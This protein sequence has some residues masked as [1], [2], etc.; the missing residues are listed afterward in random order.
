MGRVDMNEVSY[1]LTDIVRQSSDP[2]FAD[3]LSR[4]C[5]G[6]HTPKDIEKIKALEDTDTSNWQEKAVSLYLTN[7]L[8]GKENE[9]ALKQINNEKFMKFLI[10]DN[11]SVR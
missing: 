7:Y 5:E 11:V 1:E 4:V 8:A 3:V 6:N 10:A 9:K 2:E